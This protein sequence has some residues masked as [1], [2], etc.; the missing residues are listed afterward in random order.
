MPIQVL[1]VE[2]NQADAF[3][4]N[5]LLLKS[6]PAYDC[7][8]I[9]D[10]DELIN[11]LKSKKP[12]PGSPLPDVIFLDLNLPKRDGREVLKELSDLPDFCKIPVIVLSGSDRKEDID[13]VYKAGA[14]AF[15]T[16]PL[17]LT[18]YENMIAEILNVQFPRLGIG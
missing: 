4:F 17:S 8:V 9:G 15:I 13:E 14:K 3:I 7:K 18:E 16:K 2:D 12:S 6:R 5:D 11:Y 10:G 1:L